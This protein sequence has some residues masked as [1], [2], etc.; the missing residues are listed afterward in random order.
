[1]TK[2]LIEEKKLNVYRKIRGDGNCFFRALAFEILSVSRE[3]AKIEET[4]FELKDL[5]LT[6]CHEDSIPKEFRGFYNDNLLK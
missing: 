6:V 5:Q 4:F 3:L 1:M 2:K